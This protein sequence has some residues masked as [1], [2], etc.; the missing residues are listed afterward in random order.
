MKR[1]II[2]LVKLISLAC[3]IYWLPQIFFSILVEVPAFL[4]NFT[5]HPLMNFF[6]NLITVELWILLFFLF[7]FLLKTVIKS[8]PFKIHR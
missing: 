8:F 7:L 2:F 4:G 1:L 5:Y 6:S 3:F